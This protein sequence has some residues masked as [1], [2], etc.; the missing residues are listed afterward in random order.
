MLERLTA[1]YDLFSLRVQRIAESVD[2]WLARWMPWLIGIAAFAL[3]AYTAAP[4]I[5]TFFDDSLEFQTVAP[6]F[7]IAHPTGYPLYTILGGIWT[8]LLPV[9]TWAGRLNL[10]SAL[11]ASVA[12]ALVAY[13]TAR[14]TRKDDGAGGGLPNSWAGLAAA[15]TYGISP[16]WWSQA[17]IAEVY[18]FHGLFVAAILATTIGM[19]QSQQ[20]DRRMTVLMLLFGLGLTHHRTTLLLVPPVALYLVWSVPGIWRPRRVWWLW[21]TALLLPLILYLYIP[22]RAAAGVRDLN[23]SYLPTW[24]GFWNHVLAR[25]YGA[26]FADNPLATT[27]SAAQWF[28]LIRTQ[29]G[30]IGLLLALLGLAWLF[31][32]RLRPARAWWLVLGV[33]LVNLL[34]AI[35]YRVPDP[36]VFLLPAILCL[37]IFCGGGVGLV[38]RTLSEPTATFLSVVL[39]ALL[40]VPLVLYPIP[41]RHDEWS[42]HDHARRMAQAN[43]PPNSHVIGLEGEMT[44]LR[45]MQ[46]AEGLADNASM[47]NANDPAER[48]A[49]VESLMATG[50]PV[51]LTREV[52]GIEGEYSFSG[53]ADLVRVWPRGESQITLPNSEPGQS[54][55]PLLLDNGN[56]QIEGCTLRPIEGLAQP[57]QELTLYWRALAP[58]AKVL[59][60][61]MRLLDESGTPYRWP[62][63]REAVDDR[64]PLHQV[65]L[66][67][68]WQP[69]ELIQDVYTIQL[70]PDLLDDLRDDSQN[71]SPT[72]LVIIYDN[73]TTLEEGRIE[74]MF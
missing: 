69:G 50:V 9:G 1:T 44:A 29:M 23:G 15:I 39:I 19:N 20:L 38:A 34:F 57:A 18:A 2:A 70:P 58:T 53:D 64:Y 67:P 48:R 52:E 74:T 41:N 27:L 32:R 25:D 54:S 71:K 24:A 17:T 4:G 7:G 14:L 63:G 61:S 6:T 49:L 21:G 68:N 47:T 30:G 5:V 66:T 28:E 40:L 26:F 62:D 59:K 45:Y 51:Y 36:E 42:A 13:I 35:F 60:V 22:L 11:C 10:F 55:F 3:Y 65:A 46:A 8:R 43:F 73:A 56:I 72:L 12:I 33:L 16:V 31:D 37:A